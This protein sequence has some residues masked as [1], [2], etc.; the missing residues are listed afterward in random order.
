MGKK[1]DALLGRNF[2]TSKFRALVNLAISRAAILKKQRQVR[3]SQAR[4]DVVQLLNLGH[5]ERALIRVEQVIK[6]QNM[7][8]VYA[9]IE[10]YCLLL[11]ER[12]SI[13]EE[14]KVCP[15]ELKEAASGLLY[16]TS[17][18]GE[19]Q[20]LREIRAVLTSRY[21]KE[22]VARAVE[23]RNNCGV[24]PRLIQKLSVRPPDVEVRLNVLKEIASEN[25]ITLQLEGASSATLE[26]KLDKNQM[27]NQPKPDQ[28]ANS[29]GAKPEE[30]LLPE[31]QIEKGEG[32]SGSMKTR[33]KYKDVADA[34]QAAFESAAYA[35]AAARAAVELSRT[36]SHDPDDQNSPHP[37]RRLVSDGD[38]S[39]HEAAGKKDSGEIEKSDDGL[40]LE[41]IH[42]VEN[43]DSESEDEEIHNES[44]AQQSKWKKKAAEL[45][46]PMS[47]SSSDSAGG[48]LNVNS[49]SSDVMK[50]LEKDIVLDDSDDESGN[51]HSGNL[52]SD[53]KPALQIPS[54]SQVDIKARAGPKNHIA[55]PAEGLGMP[56][57]QHLNTGKRPFSVRTRGVRG[58]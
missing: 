2:K 54:S 21:G 13:I 4:S 5:H 40:A 34:A 20:E 12:V 19:F 38:E 35:A 42:P 57:V 6:E 1:I 37:R 30:S 28:S 49:M 48:S 43:Q 41:K 33:K 15:D 44:Q 45:M 26:D 46:R 50:L 56:S 14:E 22:F 53:M 11:V 3:C 16:S 29:G 24:N 32:F 23:L 17:R 31:D 58:Y 25:G 27:E 51:K 8:D 18:C 7:L 9:M 47:S 10:G 39:K 36:E 52:S 55:H